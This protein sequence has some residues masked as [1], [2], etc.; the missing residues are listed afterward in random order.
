M[1]AKGTFLSWLVVADIEKAVKFYTEIMGL[2]LKEFNKEF[3]WAELGGSEGALLG[4]AQENIE[5]GMK[6]G[7]NAVVTISVDDIHK[8]IEEIKQQGVRLIGDPIEIPGDVKMQ[9]LID[10]DGNML[11][12]V[13]NISLDV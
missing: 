3:G 9:T 11:Q 8:A 10:A 6:A 13:Q 7:T 5:Y 2:E 4:L 12:L 1:I